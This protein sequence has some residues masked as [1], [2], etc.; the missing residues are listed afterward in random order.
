MNGWFRN[1][2]VLMIPGPTEVDPDVLSAMSAPVYAHYMDQWVEVYWETIKLLKQVF[3]TERGD[4]FLITGSGTAGLEASAMSLLEP[5]DKV[6]TDDS[7]SVFAEAGGFHPVMVTSPVDEPILADDLRKVLRKEPGVKAVGL[8]HNRTWTGLANPLKELSEV[9]A[10]F[11]VSFMADAVSSL[12]SMPVN[13]DEWKLDLCSSASQK[14][15]AIPPGL[16]PLAMSARAWKIMEGR[17]QPVR[18]FYLNLKR[19]KNAAATLPYHP[20]PNTCATVLINALRLSLKKL[21]A[22]GLENVYRRHALAA[23][24]VREGMK[25]IGFKMFVKDET[26]ASPTVTAIKWPEGYDYAK[27]WNTLYNKYNLMIGHSPPQ[28]TGYFRIAHMGNTASSQYIL[29]TLSYVEKALI[30]TG[31]K[32]SPGASLEAAQKV[33][34]Q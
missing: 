1:E 2:K 30:E 26:Y 14:G 20:T 27:F 3:A 34:A 18:A 23:K 25:A 7:Y 32:L 33:L 29:P 15:P 11:D 24:A 31:Y 6:V 17:K 4:V 8:L 19:Y 13:F 22:E 28:F 10:E 5:G 9:A 16:A 12:G 21:V